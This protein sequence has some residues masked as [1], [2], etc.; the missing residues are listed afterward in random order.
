MSLLALVWLN[1][2]SRWREHTQKD[3]LLGEQI[4]NF[5]P[6]AQKRIRGEK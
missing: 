5:W 4:L 2:K 6:D 3:Q 1:L